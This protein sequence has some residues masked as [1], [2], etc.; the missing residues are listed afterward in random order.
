ME[1]LRVSCRAIS[2][3]RPTWRYLRRVPAGCASGPL[4]CARQPRGDGGRIAGPAHPRHAPTAVPGAGV[5][6]RPDRPQGLLH[7]VHAVPAVHCCCMLP[8]RP[9]PRACTA[10][11]PAASGLPCVLGE[12]LACQLHSPGATCE[13]HSAGWAALGARRHAQ[14]QCRCCTA[15]NRCMIGGAG[16]AWHGM[17]ACP[18][19][20][21]LHC[22]IGY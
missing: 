19:S 16:M 8:L 20:S 17:M 6:R 9:A 5:R 10:A 21:S 22:S 18:H 7:G 3:P 15:A 4:G 13:G 14:E 12:V 11:A 1:A 2:S